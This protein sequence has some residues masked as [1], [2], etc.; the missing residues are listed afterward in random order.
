MAIPR[1]D[2]AIG[3]VSRTTSCYVP[4]SPHH[5]D[6][7]PL[8][9]G[10]LTPHAVRTE[11]S[12]SLGRSV[13]MGKTASAV[14]HILMATSPAPPSEPAVIAGMACRLFPTAPSRGSS[15]SR[16]T[17]VSGHH[18]PSPGRL[19]GLQPPRPAAAGVPDQ[20]TGPRLVFLTSS[21]R[22]QF[23]AAASAGCAAQ[24]DMLALQTTRSHYQWGH[25]PLDSNP[26]PL[27][28]IRTRAPSTELRADGALV[29]AS[30]PAWST[31]RPPPR[32]A[33]R[34]AVPPHRHTGC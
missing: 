24:D 23:S 2:R 5:L 15:T 12:A 4:P 17:T 28:G 22:A 14:R 13:S 20:A 10:A 29:R 32:T 21:G 3:M 26:P 1:V 19:R 30:P 27:P 33:A 7:R 34:G 18:G 8:L 16:T 25:D 11:R 31:S 6:A 9:R